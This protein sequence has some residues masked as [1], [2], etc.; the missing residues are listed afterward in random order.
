MAG[1]KCSKLALHVDLKAVILNLSMMTSIR[2]FHYFSCSR[3]NAAILL[4]LLGLKPPIF[5]FSDHFTHLTP[6]KYLF[7]LYI[8][9]RGN[10]C[11]AAC[12]NTVG[13]IIYCLTIVINVPTRGSLA[14]ETKGSFVPV[15]GT[16]M[17]VI[18]YLPYI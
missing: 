16:S 6:C 3:A 9:W 2:H 17:L 12:Q 1:E 14:V 10:L 13:K 5:S 8:M 18:R 4:L 7:K 11:N 15:V